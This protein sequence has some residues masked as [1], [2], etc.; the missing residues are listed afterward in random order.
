M[1][2]DDLRSTKCRYRSSE[3]KFP[4]SQTHIVMW[5]RLQT[6]PGICRQVA[7]EIDDDQTGKNTMQEKKSLDSCDTFPHNSDQD[8][9]KVELKDRCDVKILEKT[10]KVIPS[11]IN[12]HSVTSVESP[13]STL[14]NESSD[15]VLLPNFISSTP[16]S[17]GVLRPIPKPVCSVPTFGLNTEL[18]SISNL[19]TQETGVVGSYLD[20]SDK[21]AAN[22][23]KSELKKMNS[24]PVETLKVNS[25]SGTLKEISKEKVRNDSSFSA[26]QICG[27]KSLIKP[28]TVFYVPKKCNE[29]LDVSICNDNLANDKQTVK[30]RLDEPGNKISHV[31]SKLKNIKCELNERQKE[32]DF[33][34]G[35]VTVTA[36]DFK[37][38][39]KV[40][41]DGEKPEKANGSKG[42]EMIDMKE[43]TSE[44]VNEDKRSSSRLSSRFKVPFANVKRPSL[45]RD[46][47][48]TLEPSRSKA[49][50]SACSTPLSVS[51]SSSP[52]LSGNLTFLNSV[53][54]YL[55]SRTTGRT[56]QKFKFE[57]LNL[58]SSSNRSSASGLS[59]LDL[60]V[61][62]NL[63]SNCSDIPSVG[64]S[65]C[66]N[67]DSESVSSS[68][69]RATSSLPA[70][71]D[72]V[73]KLIEKLEQVPENCMQHPMTLKR[74]LESS[75]NQYCKKR[76]NDS[77]NDSDKMSSGNVS[78][79]EISNNH[80][81]KKLPGGK[82]MKLVK[83]LVR[84]AEKGK[85][86]Q[87]ASGEFK[88]I[89]SK[90]L[91]NKIVSGQETK[92]DTD[93]VLQDLYEA[94]NIPFNSVNS[95][96][97]D[98]L[99]DVDDILNFVSVGD[100]M[101]GLQRDDR[102]SSVD[103][104]GDSKKHSDWYVLT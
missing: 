10:K 76:L 86:G 88:D 80:R 51:A 67:L 8:S 60:Q 93:S 69:S 28:S 50:T 94:L 48:F 102:S 40:E 75:S 87:I 96:M 58:K 41:Q 32:L 73:T 103:S 95:T 34:E 6:K 44:S 35:R 81:R 53:K 46:A 98:I 61:S 25:E 70:T 57:G 18:H 27:P 12:N 39:K 26:S 31:D 45:S 71:C 52:G 63:S 68:S 100:V 66:D 36:K 90:E 92:C 89:E 59:E 55:L 74:K 72:L 43:E 62:S 29:H 20:V 24:G 19:H 104:F 13:G 14:S 15:S 91:Q 47:F 49:E 78:L 65:A 54:Q 16:D 42:K 84:N 97:L 21:S 83:K 17:T 56:E 23:I 77:S 33:A 82:N 37:I 2:C 4:S 1:K 64:T 85:V 11:V 22:D 3:P 38:S 79:K 9:I 99:T 30:M 5:E 7:M 101:P